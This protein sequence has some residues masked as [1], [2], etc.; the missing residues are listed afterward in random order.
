MEQFIEYDKL[1]DSYRN[2]IDITN[3]NI[4]DIIKK[5]LHKYDMMHYKM[6]S[7]CIMSNHVHLLI[8]T[9]DVKKFIKSV[10]QI[11]HL[12]KGGSAREINLFTWQGRS[13]L[14]T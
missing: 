13:I 14:A 12:I 3:G 10:P 6:L 2:G 11:M 4:A 8:D 5:Y 9:Y 7:Y 1:L